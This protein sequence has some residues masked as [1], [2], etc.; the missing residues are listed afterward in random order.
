MMPRGAQWKTQNRV[1]RPR[2]ADAGLYL[3]QS[4]KKFGACA[5]AETLGSVKVAN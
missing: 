4:S 5:T 2:G 3:A 1:F